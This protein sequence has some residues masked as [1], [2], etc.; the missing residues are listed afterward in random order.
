MSPPLLNAIVVGLLLAL[1]QTQVSV[2]ILI[3]AFTV[4]IDDAQ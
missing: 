4:G 2:A 1:S 3:E